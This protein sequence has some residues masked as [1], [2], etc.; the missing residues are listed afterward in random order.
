MSPTKPPSGLPPRRRCTRTERLRLSA[1]ASLSSW[2]GLVA[3]IIAAKFVWP[4]LLGGV[5]WLHL[6]A[7]APA[8]RQRHALRLAAGR[9]H[10]AG[11]YLV[12]RLCGMKLWSE[13]LGVATAVLWDVIILAAVVTLAAG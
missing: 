1:D 11:L 10:G 7:A 5:S 13:K 3:I 2:S 6:R 8:A 4:D 12:P 9:R